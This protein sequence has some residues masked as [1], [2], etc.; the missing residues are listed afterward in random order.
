MVS[1][2]SYRE[3]RGSQIVIT[4]FRRAYTVEAGASIFIIIAFGTFNITIKAKATPFE[5]WLLKILFTS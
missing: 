5:E 1:K 4:N 2:Q 3:W